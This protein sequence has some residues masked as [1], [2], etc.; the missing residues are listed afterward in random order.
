MTE[1]ILIQ[2]ARELGIELNPRQIEMFSAYTTLL[3]EWNEKFNLTRITNPKEIAVKHYLDSLTCLTVV[4]FTPGALVADVGTGA[5]FP[6]IPLAIVRPD[7][8]LVLIEA[9]KKKLSFLEALRDTILSLSKDRVPQ[10]ELI[11]VRAEDAA[12]T[13]EHRERYDIV[14]SRAVAE[15]RLLAEYCL[16]L[17]KVGGVFIAMKGPDIDEELR[18]ARP[19]I[20]ALGGGHPEI[21]RLTL[22]GTDISRSLVIIKKLKSTPNQFPRHGIKIKRK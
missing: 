22:P 10:I 9:T 3:L 12:R 14:I 19:I 6:G 8:R 21:I 4:E 16:P 15:M 5:G 1:D 2:G 20:G 18:E 13:P 11:H 17:V 7:L